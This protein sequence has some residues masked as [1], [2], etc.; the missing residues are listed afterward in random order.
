MR[1]GAKNSKEIYGNTYRRTYFAGA[2]GLSHRRDALAGEIL[3][4]I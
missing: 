4:I 3:I 2:F 1:K